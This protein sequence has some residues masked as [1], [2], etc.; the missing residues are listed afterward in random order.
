M[1]FMIDAP[2]HSTM[3]LTAFD[4]EATWVFKC[5]SY[6]IHE[7][8][9]KRPAGRPGGIMDKDVAEAIAEL[10]SQGIG[11]AVHPSGSQADV[12]IATAPNGEKYEFLAAGILNLKAKGKLHLEGLQ[13]YHLAKKKTP[14]L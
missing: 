12:Y 9:E 14:N 11:V 2:S 7:G 1:S 13:E 5:A 4:F 6:W 10:K 8:F 3:R